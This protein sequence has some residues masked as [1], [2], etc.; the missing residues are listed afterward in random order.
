MGGADAHT[1]GGRRGVFGAES[2]AASLCGPQH[3]RQLLLDMLEKRIAVN[4]LAAVAAV[5]LGE[6]SDAAAGQEQRA[7]KGSSV[8]P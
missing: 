4:W 8:F 7:E 5:R 1:G 2:D 6:G 3:S